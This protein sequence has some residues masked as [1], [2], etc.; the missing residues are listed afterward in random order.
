M[1]LEHQGKRPRIHE[2]AYIAP[3]A[4]ICGDVTVGE[5]SCILFGA[6]IT[7]EGGPV[8]IG[9][10]CI[11]M[12]NAVIRGTKRHPARLGNHILVGPRAYLTGCTVEVNAFLATG[13]TVFNK[14]HIGARAEV[15][16]NGLV[17]LRTRLPP[18][19]V[20]P[21]GRIAVGDPAQILPPQDHEKIWAIQEPLNFPSTVFGLEHAPAGE[22]IMPELTRRYATFLQRHKDDQVLDPEV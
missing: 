16:I 2:S 4:T 18:D 15:R 5:N 19:A 11:I 13:A 7:A 1:L 17:H 14:A 10:Y 22:T 21:L 12:E 6:V 3:T 8:E 20:V 9:A